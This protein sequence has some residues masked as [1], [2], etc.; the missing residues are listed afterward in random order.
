[1]SDAVK[2]NMTERYSHLMELTLNVV[3]MLIKYDTKM[4]TNTKCNSNLLIY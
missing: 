1:M 4:M 2:E 3:Y